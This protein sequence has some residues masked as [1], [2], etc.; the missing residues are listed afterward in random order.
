MLSGTHILAYGSFYCITTAFALIYFN[1]IRIKQGLRLRL[2]R[3]IIYGLILHSRLFIETHSKEFTFNTLEL[4]M[5][6]L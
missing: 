3:L 5:L 2:L 1:T 6:L 4:K